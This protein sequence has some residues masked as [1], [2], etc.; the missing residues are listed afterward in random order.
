M[1]VALEQESEV[2][3]E[4]DRKDFGLPEGA[5][6]TTDEVTNPDGGISALVMPGSLT[7]HGTTRVLD[8]RV[9][10]KETYTK[11][12]GFLGWNKK[13]VTRWKDD[14][15]TLVLYNYLMDASEDIGI[16]LLGD[17]KG[18]IKIDSVGN[19]NLKG[20]VANS[21]NEAELEIVSEGGGISQSGNTTL[22]S[23]NVRLTA[24]DDITG[25]HIASL[26]S[27][28]ANGNVTDN[29][30][31]H[32]V[33]TGKGNIDITAVG[34]VL[35]DEILPG[36]VEILA[37]E[38][39]DG[40]TVFNKD[41][42][43]GN[44]T[45]NAAGNIT[46]SEGGVA[47]AGWNIN[48]SSKNGS[49]GTETQSV[50]IVS[51]DALTSNDSHGAQV[52]ASANGNIYLAEAGPGGDMRIGKIVSKEGDVHL[53]VF[54]GS[55]IDVLSGASLSSESVDSKVRHWIDA[56]LIDGEKDGDGN[57]TY[58]GAYITGLEKKR[59][60]YK[61]NVELAYAGKTKDQWAAEFVE[62]KAAV[63][64]VYASADYQNYK[65]GTGAYAGLTDAQK[66]VKLA[67]DGHKSYVA[68][69][70]YDTADAYLEQT[71]AYKY[72]QYANA[73]DYLTNDA[74]YKSLVDKA[75]NPTFEWTKEMMLYAVR[76]KLVNKNS[77]DSDQTDR[78]ASVY[79]KNISL[80]AAKGVGTFDSQP[81]TITVDD[82]SGADNVAY[83][84]QLMNAD[85]ADVTVNRD[86]NGN[87]ESFQIMGNIPLG[88]NLKEGG[89]LN[90]QAGG[91]VS[92][93]GRTDTKEER[94]AINIGTIDA[95][96]KG[97][98]GDVRVFS[99]KGIYNAL[100]SDQANITANNL[101][102]IGGAESI[103][104]SAKPLDVSLSGDLIEAR[105]DENVFIRNVKNDDYLR[106]GAMFAGDT[107]SL[108]SEK[109][110]KMSDA[111]ADIA[112]SYINAGKTLEFK[113]NTETGIVGDAGYAIR[114]LNDRA[115]V[116][117]AAG[118]A[119]I[120]GMGSLAEDIQN[121]TLVLGDVNIKH[122]FA[123]ESEGKIA[124]SDTGKI[125]ADNVMV[126]SG[127][128]LILEN[129]GN[130]F[131]TITVDGIETKTGEKPAISGDVRLQDS[132]DMLTVSINRDVTGSV[133]VKNS[134]DL[135]QAEN[136]TI[137][138]GKNVTLTSAKGSVV[139]KTGTGIQGKT[140]TA[141]SA[142]GVELQGKGNQFAT[143]TVQSSDANA[144]LQ[145][146]V[147]VQDSTDN[148][149]L[150]IESAVNGNITVENKK[151]QGTLHA[152]TELQANGDGADA[153]GDITLQSD[154]S[155]Q[156]DSRLTA[157]NDVKAASTNGAMTVSDDV[158]ASNNIE[159]QSKETLQTN[160]KLTAIQ[161][162]IALTSDA[163][164][165]A[166]KEEAKAKTDVT[167]SAKAGSVAVDGAVT[168][169]AGDVIANAMGAVATK[170]VTANQNVKLT[171]KEG[172][173]TT[174]AAVTAEA[175]KVEATAQSDITA[176]GAVKAGSDVTLLSY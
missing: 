155:L 111:N 104:T 107:I 133:S 102:L 108:N 83:M 68:Y 64:K 16:G 115:D 29:I 117:I 88:V 140:V 95:T 10:D 74:T 89:I 118:F 163:G 78:E 109:G 25:L 46:Q 56:G 101:I 159:L 122:D 120:K 119:H 103:G 128:S 82:L 87:V 41:A 86:E 20:N 90:V 143:I 69:A 36:N 171:S 142:K 146:S 80:T 42:V 144:P 137:K 173:I 116:N 4:S 79:G 93:A 172:D 156:T 62:Q 51:P 167:L 153:K 123:V 30:Q 28:D 58:K 14:A 24:H 106:L 149:N 15:T 105:A 45:L 35:G 139:Q 92:V 67:K 154:G 57:Y 23:E 9:Y 52:N 6:L 32:A 124:Q 19:V 150:S 11:K 100:N 81:T 127:E 55:F 47:V 77:G 114:M 168:S 126:K 162:E 129:T 176:E 165:V 5:V 145:G 61:A 160:G 72:S 33:S 97:A 85:A 18:R 125:V 44:V 2:I 76:E 138:A 21:H 13:K 112:D 141:V 38:S 157:A 59:D 7:L 50:Q 37:L 134:G 27:K 135:V 148:L 158:S 84:K 26:G 49:I 39:Q 12:S 65:A 17:E 170:D 147:L 99:E 110:F 132:A 94:S 71:A 54:D 75:N 130:Q 48:L 34:G 53:A 175:G 152:I 70:Q 31:L 43:L 131:N 60:D 8:Q 113:A 1:R 98:T 63:E 161:G 166:V 22:R 169:R 91:T 66:A 73:E 174:G 121:G 164:N 40:S 3:D 151:S 96:Q 136:T